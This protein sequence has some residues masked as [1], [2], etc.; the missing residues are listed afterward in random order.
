MSETNSKA[1]TVAGERPEAGQAEFVTMS[2]DGQLFGIP[3]LLV[4]DALKAQKIT[5][6]LALGV[7]TSETPST[8]SPKITPKVSK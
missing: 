4:Q 5:S 1:L 7:T 3:V 8:G 6:S 2:V